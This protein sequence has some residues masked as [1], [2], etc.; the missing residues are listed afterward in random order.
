MAVASSTPASK[1][2]QP[3]CAAATTPCGLARPTS[4]QSAAKTA[5]GAPGSVVTSA[6]PSRPKQG[7]SGL[8][9][10]TPLPWDWFKKRQRPDAMDW[11]RASSTSIAHDDRGPTSP[12]KTP[13]S[14]TVAGVPAT[15]IRL[16]EEGR[17]VEV[18]VE[19]EIVVAADVEDVASALGAAAGVWADETALGPV[20]A[21]SA[22]HGPCR[23][24]VSG[25][26]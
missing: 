3:T 22:R 25:H 4:A 5:T 15:A 2:R 23:R 8:K 16:A 6:S 7:S 12:S 24:L 10:T 9:T 13:L 18:V 11:R 20:P 14:T 19:V 21:L 17:D 1:L 26:P